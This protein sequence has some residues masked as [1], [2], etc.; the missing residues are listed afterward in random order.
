MSAKWPAERHFQRAEVAAADGRTLEIFDSDP[1]NTEGPVIVTGHHYNVQVATPNAWTRALSRAARFIAVNPRG[2][3]GS[4][5]A[6]S[7]EDLT[8]RRFADD[9]ESVRANYL[10]GRRICFAGTSTGGFVGLI[11]ALAY[12]DGLTGMI[13]NGT[14]PSYKFFAD[15]DSIWCPENPRNAKAMAAWDDPA[16]LRQIMISTSLADPS[17]TEAFIADTA[18]GSMARARLNHLIPEL[19]EGSGW[20]VGGRLHEIEVPT[21]VIDGRHDHQC[22]V[23][24]SEQIAAAIP[25]SRLVIFEDSGHFAYF[26]EPERFADE[27]AQFVV[28]LSD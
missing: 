10:D 15:E 3:G 13:L 22:P 14:A 24:H 11:F 5:D 18:A 7:P 20:D 12:P 19:T 28:N 23:A 21:L 27:V 16:A 1:A 8:M 25:G 4:A 6:E 2:A 26:E 17:R 9:L